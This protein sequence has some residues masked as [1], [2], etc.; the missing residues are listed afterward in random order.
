V[1][2]VRFLFWKRKKEGEAMFGSQ[3]I[4]IGLGLVFVYF[5]L[6]VIC[7]GVNEMLAGLA[8]WRAK[9]LFRGIENLLKDQG[10]PDLEKNFYE[11]PLIKSLYRKREKPSYIP[12]QTFALAFIDLISPAG[13]ETSNRISDLRA[14]VEKMDETSPLRKTLLILLEEAGNDIQALQKVIETWFNNAMDRVSGWYKR[15]AQFFVFIIAALLVGLSNA[16]TLQIVRTLSRGPALRQEVSQR[17]ADLMKPSGPPPSAPTTSTPKRSGEKAGAENP[18][19]PSQKKEEGGAQAHPLT[20][21]DAVRELQGIQTAGIPLGWTAK[22]KGGEWV[23][24]FIGLILT[25]FAIS[26]G[27]PFWFDVLN[28]IVSIRSVGA[29]PEE[30]DEK[31]LKGRRP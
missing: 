13:T 31:R 5:V 3:T 29:S 10:V 19:P 15:K 2:A 8:R 1:P 21:K 28:K 23:N 20:L 14:V 6:S 24:K 9:S 16:D 4:D 27:A 22:P 30:K 7:S 18:S 12:S 17:V 25:V 11:H 26:L